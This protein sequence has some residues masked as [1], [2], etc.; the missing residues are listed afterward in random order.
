MKFI[1]FSV[2]L[3]ACSLIIHSCVKQDYDTPPDTSQYDPG[4]TVHTTL[5][6]LSDMVQDM[7]ANAWRRMGDTTIYG[8]V[9]ANDQSGNFYKQI[10]IQDTS[11]GGIV[12]YIDRTGLYADYPVGRKV[13]IKLDSL[14]VV[15]YRGL[16]E[17]VY[18]VDSSGNTAGIPSGLINNYIVKA[19]YPT[20]VDTNVVSIVDLASS[21]A[22]YVSTLVR[23]GNVQFNTASAG[24]PYASPSSISSGTSR[25]VEDCSHT[26]NVT[27]YNSAY[28]SF[29]PYITPTGNGTLNCVVSRY[30]QTVQ[31]LIRDTL[32]VQFTETRCP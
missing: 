21:P 5:R 7:P 23:I 14:C 10:V 12:V 3:L 31:L 1:R 22:R 26:A 30:Y 25:M 6:Y 16:P 32:D 8:V 4:L 29:Q 28:A 13:Y 24:Q 18:N 19:N 20:P 9:I 17:I 11:I 15:N 27:M 2:I